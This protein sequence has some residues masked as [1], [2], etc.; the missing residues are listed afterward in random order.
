MTVRLLL[1]SIALVAIVALLL[2][3]SS[4]TA[5]PNLA[6]AVTAVSTAAL[7]ILTL[8][9]AVFAYQT[10]ILEVTPLVLLDCRTD[11]YDPKK[12]DL[13]VNG[14]VG[15]PQYTVAASKGQ[16]EIVKAFGDKYDD[17]L[18][19]SINGPTMYK[20][21]L[22]NLGK[23]PVLALKTTFHIRVRSDPNNGPEASWDLPIPA[24]FPGALSL[25]IN[26]PQGGVYEFTVLNATPFFAFVDPGKEAT[27]GNIGPGQKRVT[28]KLAFGTFT[29][30]S[31]MLMPGGPHANGAKTEK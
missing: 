16:A 10:Y 5:A 22:R 20:C 27:A 30:S 6:E 18:V 31:N 1:A 11:A 13:S 21:S 29:T 8:V 15:Y 24:D 14:G 4:R 9:V 17:A 12:Y 28:I 19:H 26:I 3:F 23:S 25:P 7:A 2:T